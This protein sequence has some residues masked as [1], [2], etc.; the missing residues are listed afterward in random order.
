MVKRLWFQ[1]AVIRKNCLELLLNDKAGANSALKQSTPLLATH[2]DL[3]SDIS[4]AESHKL[5][6]HLLQIISYRSPT[7][8]G[9]HHQALKMG[10]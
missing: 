9:D 7:L 3:F 8:I 1:T 2:I 10:R 4:R 5:Q 6:N